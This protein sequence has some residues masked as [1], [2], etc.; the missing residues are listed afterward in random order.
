[1]KRLKGHILP[2]H[3]LAYRAA[4]HVVPVE[5]LVNVTH[6]DGVGT[7]ATF[8]PVTCDGDFRVRVPVHILT[9]AAWNTLISGSN[10]RLGVSSAPAGTPRA[11]LFGLAG[12]ANVI[13]GA[14]AIAV[15]LTSMAELVRK[16]DRISIEIDGVE[17][18]AASGPEYAVPITFS[19]FGKNISGLGGADYLK[20]CYPVP[21]EIH[22]TGELAGL[23]KFNRADRVLRNYAPIGTIGSEFLDMGNVE[24]DSVVDGSFSVDGVRAIYTVKNSWGQRQLRV[25]IT[26]EAG[27]TYKFSARTLNANR[28]T[29][30][31]PNIKDMVPDGWVQND[32]YGAYQVISGGKID[33]VVTIPDD[34]ELEWVHVGVASPGRDGDPGYA[35]ISVREADGWGMVHNMSADAVRRYRLDDG[36]LIGNES[37][38]VNGGFDQ[39][40]DWIHSGTTIADGRLIFGA[41]TT[42]ADQQN[43]LSV[44]ERY[45]FIFDTTDYSF[46]VVGVSA[47]SIVESGL[48][49][50]AI[51]RHTFDGTAETSNLRLVSTAEGNSLD[52]LKVYRLLAA[53]P[54]YK[55]HRRIEKLLRNKAGKIRP[56]YRFNGE[57]MRG[58]LPPWV[59]GQDF[60][61]IILAASTKT[62]NK[63][64]LSDSHTNST[65]INVS[66]STVSVW[67]KGVEYRGAHSGQAH[68]GQL[69][70]YEITKAGQV[71]VIELNGE[72]LARE[73]NVPLDWGEMDL[74][75]ADDKNG[76]VNSYFEGSMPGVVLQD[77]SAPLTNSR[78][79]LMDDTNGI[80]YDALAETG[81]ELL[82]DRPVMKAGHCTIDGNVI[83]AI[84]NSWAYIGKDLTTV[85]GRVYTA[86][87]SAK[88][89]GGNTYYGR[90]YDVP[91]AQYLS[92][93][94]H[95]DSE[96]VAQFV[97]T[98]VSE[99][100]RIYVQRTGSMEIGETLEALRLEARETP[101]AGQIENAPANAYP[102]FIYQGDHVREWLSPELALFQSTLDRAPDHIGGEWEYFYVAQAESGSQ[103]R[104]RADVHNTVPGKAGGFST[105]TG[106]PIDVPFRV[107]SDGTAGGDYVASAAGDIRI[108][109]YAGSDV[110]HDNITIRKLLKEAV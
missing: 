94:L 75:I 110:Y 22:K 6:F 74:A 28:L 57:G 83:T 105:T 21:A 62:S 73:E 26:L 60:K 35:E 93:A 61:I 107:Y 95:L 109:K 52:N 30:K 13:T 15:G 18:A 102:K 86:T 9:D 68:T 106:I 10:A 25:P 89:L 96:S 39:D 66:T 5:E 4:G 56:I 43:A 67:H 46:G 64:L 90:A 63:V 69:C 72:L 71:L 40:S 14:D 54:L 31:F 79:Y 47:T 20:G 16:G 82:H 81:P 44:G 53:S 85:S 76:G 8:E 51:G 23:Y 17:R 103:Y 32:Y 88:T 19:C 99:K 97:F 70:V 108:F 100:T 11:V 84:A 12:A 48:Y 65:H 59:P 58:D 77:L 50:N 98:A 49:G 24:P 92:A 29:L 78:V 37:I 101:N 41:A 27:K 38:S 2:D 33:V 3:P 55:L 42:Y 45:R 91:G 1:M 80:L 104:I 36:D 87:V 7:H 34:A